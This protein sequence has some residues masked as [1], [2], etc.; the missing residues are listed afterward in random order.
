MKKLIEKGE[1]CETVE[2]L[3]SLPL[4]V[5]A[6]LKDGFL[7]FKRIKSQARSDYN[8]SAI[9]ECSKDKYCVL[10]FKEIKETEIPKGYVALDVQDYSVASETPPLARNYQFLNYCEVI[11]FLESFKFLIKLFEPKFE[12]FSGI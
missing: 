7:H 2:I 10:C 5:Y 8:I 1:R 9:V 12:A 11:V 6:N 4:K 3:Y